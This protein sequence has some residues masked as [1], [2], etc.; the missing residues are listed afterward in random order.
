MNFCK[1]FLTLC[2]TALALGCGSSADAP[3]TTEQVK[4]FQGG[5]MPDSF[6]KQFQADQQASAQRTADAVAKAKAGH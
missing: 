1:Y 3:K 4:S 2:V 5:P 6:R